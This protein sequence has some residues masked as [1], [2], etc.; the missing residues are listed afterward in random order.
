M[1]DIYISK[2]R[3]NSQD[4]IVEIPEDEFLSSP[5]EDNE[6]PQKKKKHRFLRF[7][8]KVVAA[9]FILSSIFIFFFAAASGYTR[10][11]LEKN[12]YISSSQLK[13]SP[14][15]TNILLLGVDGNAESSSRSDSMI[16]VSVDFAH[17]KIKLTS[18]L[19]DSWVEIPSKGKKAKL[20]AACS[21]GGPQLVCDTIE[22]NFGV[23]I[24]HFVMVDFDMF[25]Q[26]IDSLGGVEVE[27]TKKEANFINSTTRQNVDYGDSVRLNG[28]EALVYCR[29]RKLDSD[30]MRT[31]RQRKVITALINQAKKAGIPKLIDTMRQVFPLIQTD[32]SPLEI[33][34]F[35]YKAGAGIIAFD[36]EQN[37]VPIDEHMTPKTINGQW[38]EALDIEATKDYLI[39]YIYTN[40]IKIEE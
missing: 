4:F 2:K 34:A 29:I 15:V 36:I 14:F 12:K 33:T 38:V 35:A 6:P 8:A 17:A 16:L 23:D 40:N 7:I 10:N 25:T 39:E 26:I 21:Y 22:Y 18:F 27:V 28:D 5:P 20:N 3:K 19:R 13:T 1:D 32:M 24:D 37:R 11:D 31:Y 9:I 30:Y